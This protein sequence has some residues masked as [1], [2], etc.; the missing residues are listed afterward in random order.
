MKFNDIT[1][2]G[3][4]I[5]S[6]RRHDTT[7][8][9][10]PAI[11]T[12]R[13]MLKEL[14]SGELETTHGI[15]GLP[16]F[17]VSLGVPDDVHSELGER[18]EH[19]GRIFCVRYPTSDRP[20]QINLVLPDGSRDADPENPGEDGYAAGTVA[21]LS[22]AF[23]GKEHEG[24]VLENTVREI[25]KARPVLATALDPTAFKTASADAIET[26]QIAADFATCFAA[27]L[28]LED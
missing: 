11:D 5:Y 15:D 6:R 4:A 26:I 14:R 19:R 9:V 18:V 21:A 1:L 20:F 12:C 3:G 17:F 10:Q 28:L 23:A 2:D 27:A 24:E 7:A 25:F 16:P 22:A 13:R 8:T